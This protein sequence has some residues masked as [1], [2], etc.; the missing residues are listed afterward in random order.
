[1]NLYLPLMLWCRHVHY[2]FTYYLRIGEGNSWFTVQQRNNQGLVNYV[3]KYT[4]DNQ[5]VVKFLVKDDLNFER[6]TFGR[7][8]F[9]GIS[10]RFAML[11]EGHLNLAPPL[12]ESGKFDDLLKSGQTISGTLSPTDNSLAIWIRNVVSTLH[13]RT[14][15]C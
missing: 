13:T 1:L 11:N 3:I 15:S 5:F 2:S 4:R 6:S 9:E 10:A 8:K 7:L 14:K 12:V